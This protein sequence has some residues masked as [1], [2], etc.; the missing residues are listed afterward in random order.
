M[1]TPPQAPR[2]LVALPS[3]NE[4][5]VLAQT[6]TGLKKCGYTNIL[7][8]DD[9]ST[10]DT[11]QILVGL[12]VAV[13]RHPSNRG[14][15]AAVKTAILW[16]LEHHYDILVTFDAD[17]QHNPEDIQCLVEPIVSGEVDVVL[18]HRVSSGMPRTK[19]LANAL[20]SRLLSWRFGLPYRDTQSGL[21][22]FRVARLAGVALPIVDR[23]DFQTHV[24]VAL[25]RAGLRGAEVPVHALYS[26]YSQT[27]SHRYTWAQ[28]LHMFCRAMT[29]GV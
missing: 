10:D 27:K 23:F 28:A 17:G 14:Q 4:A 26:P 5:T 20:A 18:G 2:I 24:L 22:A 21:R 7:V 9:G 19:A 6:I 16:A 3:Y 29:S 13:A 11:S 15:G 12:C 8:V 25:A 1:N